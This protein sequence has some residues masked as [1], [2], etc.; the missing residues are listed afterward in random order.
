MTLLRDLQQDALDPTVDITTVLRKARILAARLNNA[1]F[2]AWIRHE[3]DGYPDGTNLPKYRVLNIDAKA[4]LVMGLQHMQ[5]APIM[6][7]QVPEEFRHW[8][9]TSS[10]FNS[11]SELSALIAGVN[12][13]G[14]RGLQR[15]WPQEL[16]IKFGS[17]GYG[18]GRVRVQF[19]VSAHGRR[20]ALPRSLES[21]KL[22]A[23]GS[24]NSYCRLR[25]RRRPRE[26]RLRARPHCLKNG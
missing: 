12:S 20:S 2:V 15:S 4:H 11:V 9:T 7:S 5:N 10:C 21:L 8:A 16:A 19:S 17:A 23:T 22:S 24:L 18:G 3:L 13:K 14:H 1:E 6:A 26:R 25:Q